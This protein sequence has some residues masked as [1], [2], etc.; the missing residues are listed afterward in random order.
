MK[1]RLITFVRHLVKNIK[2]PEMRILPGQLAFYF[3][4]MLIPLVALLGSIVTIIHVPVDIMDT[5]SKHLPT[6]VNNI[7]LQV[8][9][10]S[11]L[12][13]NLIVFFISSLVLAS[14]GTHSIIIASNHIYKIKDKNY[15]NRRIKA[16]FM[17]INLI[18]LLVF[19]I[20][21]LV[22]GDKI[23]AFVCSLD[24]TNHIHD[25]IYAVYKVLKYPLAL[26]LIYISIKLL[27]TM[28]PDTS[29]KSKHVT[30]GAVFTSI[31][32]I[33]ATR[34]YSVY[35]DK[36][37]HYDSFYGSISNLIVL[38]FWIYILAYVFVLGMS[39]NATRYNLDS[40][41]EKKEKKDINDLDKD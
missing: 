9:T 40:K 6:A 3:V 37:S 23:V 31:T 39:L 34:I 1:K 2:K 35:V 24:S 11:N 5:I 30:Y 21:F 8:S 41:E 4:L 16:L 26:M 15:L 29:I 14:N 25:L 33:V 20:I 18:M 12:S 13:F 22:F 28:A 19:V 7:L 36:F 27:Y 32:W 17:M 10:E 38:L